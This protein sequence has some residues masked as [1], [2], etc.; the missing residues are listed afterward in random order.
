MAKRTG[1]RNLNRRT[2]LKALGVSA[3]GIGGLASNVTA[4]G[5]GG[6]ALT[7]IGANTFDFSGDGSV[8]I[9]VERA[10][11]S[12]R[13]RVAHITSAGT[14][15]VDYATTVVNTGSVTL[16]DLS[17]LTYDYYATP[18]NEETPDEVY[19][20][21]EDTDG[22]ARTVWHH[23]EGG[24]TGQWQTRDVHSEIFGTAGFKWNSLD[25]FLTRNLLDTFSEDAEI[26]RVGAGHGTTGGDGAVSDIYF[27]NLQINGAGRGQFP[28]R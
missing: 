16:G 17:S 21:I 19:L 2:V 6:S 22:N 1:D 12:G 9:S 15:T 11:K 3:A 25:G 18:Q 4:Q 10:R 14:K 8:D 24:A 13:P 26:V 27:D 23:T 20:L 28:T 5:R 7:N